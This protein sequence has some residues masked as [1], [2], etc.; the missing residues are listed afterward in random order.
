[1]EIYGASG[2]HQGRIAATGTV[3]D[4]TERIQM[5]EALRES[6]EQHRTILHTAMDG[7]CLVDLKGPLLQVNEAYCRM[8]GYK[9]EE[10]LTMSISDLEATETSSD[11]AADIEKIMTEGKDRFESQHRRKDG[12]TFE[13]EVTT[14]YQRF[15]GGQFVAFIRD[16]T[17]RRQAEIALKQSEERY[18]MILTTLRWESCTLTPME[19]S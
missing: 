8:S 16:I 9:E 2:V 14:Q 1:M 18:R 4:I 10:L 13:V 3:L 15:G 17:E 12:S 19:S 6:E 5:E 11:T 7:F